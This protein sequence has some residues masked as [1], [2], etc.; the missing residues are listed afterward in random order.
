MGAGRLSGVSAGDDLR[1]A[2]DKPYD[3]TYDTLPPSLKL[4]MTRKEHLWLTDGQKADLMR[5]ETEPEWDEPGGD[6]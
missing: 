4:I 3:G 1:A 6:Q 2:L 5:V